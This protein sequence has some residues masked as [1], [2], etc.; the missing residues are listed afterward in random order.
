MIVI[1][2]MG[3]GLAAYGELA[4]HAA[5]REKEAEL[6]FRGDQY[7]EAIAGYFRKERTYPRELA[8]LLQDRR[9][10][11]PVRHL[12]KLYPDPITGQPD[13]GLIEAPGGGIMGVYSKS[14]ARPVKSGGFRLADKTSLD[15]ERYAD[16]KF[17]YT[18][19]K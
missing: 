16:W 4:S 2:L 17:F 9:Y 12:R 19:P 8:A 15:A 3:G 7:R 10:P 14:E 5:Q 11:M 1:A 6:L 13:W 18:P